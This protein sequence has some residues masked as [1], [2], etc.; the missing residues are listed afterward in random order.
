MH[1]SS[2]ASRGLVALAALSLVVTGCGREARLP[3]AAPA[4]STNTTIQTQLD[5]MNGRAETARAHPEPRH[6]IIE[7]AR[8]ALGAILTGEQTYFQKWATYIDADGADDLRVRLGV[9]LAVTAPYWDFSVGGASRSGFVAEAR[10]RA[11]T[12]A[13]GIVVTMTYVRGQP[14]AWAITRTH[15][16]APGSRPAAG[17]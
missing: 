15:G 2:R 1:A 6:P 11:R 14:I 4:A 12:K 8:A 9:E 16:N 13:H 7:E 10:G 17:S 3:T 5:A